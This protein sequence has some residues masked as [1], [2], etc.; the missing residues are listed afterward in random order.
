MDPYQLT[1]KAL[2]QELG[3]RLRTTRLNL[4]MTQDE[5]AERSGVGKSAL[6]AAEKGGNL[7]LLNMLRLL[8]ALEKLDQLDLFLPETG[9]SPLQMVKLQGKQRVRARQKNVAVKKGG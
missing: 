7:T 4:N 9:P 5:L 1:D 3:L 6:R 8:R 2:L